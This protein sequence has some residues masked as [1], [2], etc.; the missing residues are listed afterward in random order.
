MNALTTPIRVGDLRADHIGQQVTL[1]NG[2][3]T[4]TDRIESLRH[5]ADAD[6]PQAHIITDNQWDGVWPADTVVT[7]HAEGAPT[8]ADTAHTAAAAAIWAGVDEGGPTGKEFTGSI[9][10]EDAD[11]LARLALQAALS[12]VPA[13]DARKPITD[14]KDAR[15]GE[16]LR[17][18]THDGA[19]AVSTTA[20]VTGFDE[21]GNALADGDYPLAVADHP[22]ARCYVRRAPHDHRPTPATTEN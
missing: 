6:G 9:R 11:Y 10:R 5:F 14:L 15:I 19:V 20:V 17:V 12:A 21:D 13:G 4:R 3:D 18:D 16:D 8:V 1:S 7:L 2:E 22:D